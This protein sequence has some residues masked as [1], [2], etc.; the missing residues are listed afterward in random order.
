MN[1]QHLYTTLFL[2]LSSAYLSACSSIAASDMPRLSEA[3]QKQLASE[4][5]GHLR[6]THVRFNALDKDENGYIS[7]AEFNRSGDLAFERMDTNKDG[8]LSAADPKPEPRGQDTRSE[9]TRQQQA[10]RTEQPRRERLLKMPTT[11][12][13][14]GMLAMYDSNKDGVISRE[15]YAKGRAAQF[16]ATDANGDGQLSYDEYVTEFAG[17]LDQQISQTGKKAD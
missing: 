17:R 2:A 14:D 8:A 9:Q 3:Q 5:A 7:R 11:H 15:E 1:K 16:A 10:E 4:R 13:V 12:S 6:Q